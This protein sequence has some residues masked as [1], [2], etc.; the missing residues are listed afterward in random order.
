MQGKNRPI[1]LC[2]CRCE[3][4]IFL[5]VFR[6][7]EVITGIESIVDNVTIYYHPPDNKALWWYDSIFGSGYKIR[8]PNKRQLLN[9]KKLDNI[10]I[11]EIATTKETLLCLFSNLP[12][13]KHNV[14]AENP[15]V[16]QD[17]SEIINGGLK[18]YHHKHINVACDCHMVKA[19]NIE[20]LPKCPL[21]GVRFD[22]VLDS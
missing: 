8:K 9:E 19:R 21:C 5:E 1:N 7:S 12:F 20:E 3:D 2:S 6:Y 16:L 18:P 14:Y 15:I 4:E 22:Y 11:G 10:N 17:M 13:I